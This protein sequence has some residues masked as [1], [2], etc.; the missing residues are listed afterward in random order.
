M[1]HNFNKSVYLNKI[2]IMKKLSLLLTLSVLLLVACNDNVTNN[3]ENNVDSNVVETVKYPSSG[4]FYEPTEGNSLIIANPIIYDVI[5][6]NTDPSDDW[7]EFCLSNTDPKAISNVIYNA[8]YQEKLVPYHYRTDTIIP[9][10]DVKA[11]EKENSYKTLGK[12]QFEEEWFL[13]E[14]NL[15]MYKKVNSITFGYE[16]VNDNGEVYGYKPGF[17]VYLDE[18]H[19]K[20]SR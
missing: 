13:D 15:T 19:N 2:F 8:I 10:A 12:I 5:V 20:V 1:K 6:K 11:F 17:K 4:N 16:L 14:G 9:I 7:T 3:N 18:E